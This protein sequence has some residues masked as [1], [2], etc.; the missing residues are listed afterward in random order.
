[1]FVY[2]GIKTQ[3]R[4]VSV[5]SFQ[6]LKKI[7]NLLNLYKNVDT[8]LWC[9]AYAPAH[10]LSRGSYFLKSAWASQA[11]S[12]KLSLMKKLIIC[13]RNA[14]RRNF[15]P[16]LLMEPILQFHAQLS[17]QGFVVVVDIRIISILSLNSW[18][19][20]PNFSFKLHTVSLH[21]FFRRISYCPYCCADLRGGIDDHGPRPVSSYRLSAQTQLSWRIW[22]V[23]ENSE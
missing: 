5:L 12:R 11:N 15:L 2:L 3:S 6:R 10:F 22:S 20:M 21:R 17:L 4:T 19:E 16:H 23:L 7:Q 9:E 18:H 14:V 8:F 13:L 1:M